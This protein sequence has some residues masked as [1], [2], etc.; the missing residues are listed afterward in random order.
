[1]DIGK[2]V[3]TS[4]QREGGG[5]E[6][7]LLI[8]IV[9]SLYSIYSMAGSEKFIAANRQ[10]ARIVSSNAYSNECMW[11]CVVFAIINKDVFINILS[12]LLAN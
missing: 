7:H 4:G 6:G 3:A 2:G 8:R 10:T 9:A 5:G 11:V 1:M 12:T